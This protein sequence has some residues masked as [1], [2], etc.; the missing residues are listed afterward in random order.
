MNEQ[1]IELLNRH[2]ESMTATMVGKLDRFR[3]F[4]NRMKPSVAVLCADN[5]LRMEMEQVFTPRT[6]IDAVIYSSVLSEVDVFDVMLSDVVIAVS[7]AKT[8]A[9]K[10]MYEMLQSLSKMEKEVYFILGRWSSMAKTTEMSDS[11]KKR[12]PLE[13]PFSKIVCVMNACDVDVSGFAKATEIADFYAAQICASFSKNHEIQS[14][15]LYKHLQVQVEAFYEEQRKRI[16]WE[17]TVVRNAQLTVSVKQDR[18]DVVLPHASVVMQNVIDRITKSIF[19]ISLG[20]LEKDIQSLDLIFQDSWADAEKTVKQALANCVELIFKEFEDTTNNNV[21]IKTQATI[22]EAV[23]DMQAIATQIFM[24][25]QIDDLHK[26]ELEAAVN[27]PQRLT[28]IMDKYGLLYD[29]LINRAKQ[30]IFANIYSFDIRFDKS[31]DD[32]LRRLGQKIASALDVIMSH[33]PTKDDGDETPDGEGTPNS[34]QDVQKNK[35]A[36]EVNIDSVSIDEADYKKMQYEQFRA[37]VKEMIQNVA[38]SAAG[39]LYTCAD[40]ARAEITQT[41]SQLLKGYFYGILSAL[42]RIESHLSE[43][44]KTYVLE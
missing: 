42:Q 22:D 17:E 31:F 29:V 7:A 21:R 13:F 14:E 8:I 44:Y 28:Q 30:K 36:S 20:E 25:V 11:R 33:E 15:K 43:R 12:V 19:D 1:R 38:E 34:E 5:Q 2:R 23:S 37:G 6:D 39:V 9:P 16:V 27:D 24:K 10:G 3:Q 18:F 26:A 41:A 32:P 4:I 35:E 40:E